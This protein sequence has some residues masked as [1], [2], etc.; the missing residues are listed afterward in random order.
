MQNIICALYTLSKKLHDAN[1]S[2]WN[3]TIGR[4]VI[5]AYIKNVH[6]IVIL[7]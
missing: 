4:H 6:K 2:Q 5:C 3:A 1:I 7:I